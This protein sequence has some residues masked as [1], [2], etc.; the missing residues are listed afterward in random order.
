MADNGKAIGALAGIGLLLLMGRGKK[1]GKALKSKYYTIE[2]VQRS[3]TATDENITAQFKPLSQQILANANWYAQHILDPIADYLGAAPKVTSWWRSDALNERVGGASDS[4]H[5]S[6]LA[7]D[8][9]FWKMDGQTLQELNKKIVE[10]VM[11]KNLVFDE[12]I[13][14][15]SKTQPTSIHIGIK[16]EGNKM[17]YLFKESDGSYSAMSKESV[18]KYLGIS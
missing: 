7:T 11:R 16:P 6:A 9:E 8:L 13:L 2:D 3:K 10:A 15:G 17:E 12:V 5:L 18:K 14:Y 1:N 4:L